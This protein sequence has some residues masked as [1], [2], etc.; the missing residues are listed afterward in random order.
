MMR[1]FVKKCTASLPNIDVITEYKVL[2]A[3]DI[4]FYIHIYFSNSLEVPPYWYLN[5]GV[6]TYKYYLDTLRR[7]VGLKN[8]ES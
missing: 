5:R 4:C 1:E 7:L 8:R 2:P 6:S 3:E